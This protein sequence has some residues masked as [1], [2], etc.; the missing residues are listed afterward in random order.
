[1]THTFDTKAE[2]NAQSG[3]PIT[4]SYKCGA[5]ATVLVVGLAI[6]S[7]ASFTQTPTYNSINMKQAGSTQIPST[8]I[9]QSQIW[10]LLKPSKN[11]AYNI[12]VPNPGA[13]TM[14]VMASSYKASFGKTSAFD[15]SGGG[16]NNS[17]SNPSAS[18]TPSVAG[19]AVVDILTCTNTGAVTGNGQTLLYKTAESGSWDSAGQYALRTVSGA[20]N[21]SYTT[22]L[23]GWAL[24][25]AAIQEVASPVARTIDMRKH[26]RRRIRI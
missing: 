17:A 23:S 19:D 11:A 13:L 26:Y 10:Y 18:I 25:V 8:Q 3:N 20:F 24:A 16:S 1:M 15:T 7:R 2:T 6:H 21:M 5:G 9:A 22:T 12:S 4:L 14:T